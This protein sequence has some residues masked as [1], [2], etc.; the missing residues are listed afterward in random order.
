MNFED[1][2]PSDTSEDL[3]PSD[4]RLGLQSWST[5]EKYGLW[6]ESVLVVA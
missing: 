5:M 2:T 3:T 6:E 4:T 1:L